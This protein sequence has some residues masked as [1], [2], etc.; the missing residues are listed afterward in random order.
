MPWYTVILISAG[1][2]WLMLVACLLV[3]MCS[4]TKEAGGFA[5]GW[6]VRCTRCGRT[7]DAAEAGLVRYKAASASKRTLGFCSGCYGFRWLAIERE[8]GAVEGEP[9]MRAQV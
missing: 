1:A 3:V 6:R 5:P 8:P 7:R 4:V 9:E 2:A